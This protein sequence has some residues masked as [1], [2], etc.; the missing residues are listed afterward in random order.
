MPPGMIDK[1]AA[2]HLGGDGEKVCA[3]LPRHVA[4]I[5]QAQIGFID[6]GRRLERV[7]GIFLTHAAPC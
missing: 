1:N 6:K 4:L 3:V 7:T 2:H 5:H